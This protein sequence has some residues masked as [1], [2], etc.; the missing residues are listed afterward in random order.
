MVTGLPDEYQV[1]VNELIQALYVQRLH[2]L[3]FGLFSEEEINGLKRFFNTYGQEALEARF[4]SLLQSK[5]HGDLKALN[6]QAWRDAQDSVGW[7]TL[8]DIS[9]I[10]HQKKSDSKTQF[11]KQIDKSSVPVVK[12]L[13]VLHILQHVVSRYLTQ[14]ERDSWEE[15]LKNSDS[16]QLAAFISEIESKTGKKFSDIVTESVNL[17]QDDVAVQIRATVD[18]FSRIMAKDN[19]KSYEQAIINEDIGKLTQIFQT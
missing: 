15:K 1:V 13:T 16:Q 17:V 12:V 11:E 5:T 19:G 2:A 8:L 9:V 10:S 7:L 18:E 6:L 4:A 14:A 3:V